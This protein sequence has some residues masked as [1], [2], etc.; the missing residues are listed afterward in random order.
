M[1]PPGFGVDPAFRAAAARA[2][3][4]RRRRLVRPVL[5]GL[6][7]LALATAGWR[8]TRDRPETPPAI[9]TG[10]DLAMVPEAEPGPET[11]AAPDPSLALRGLPRDPMVLRLSAGPSAPARTLPGPPGFEPGRAGPPAPDRLTLIEVG[12]GPGS[13]PRALDPPSSREDLALYQ[14]RR[15]RALA[16]ARRSSSAPGDLAL[17]LLPEAA[18]HPF[19]ADSLLR[20]G[21]GAD[22]TTALTGAGLGSEAARAATGALPPLA[23]PPRLAALRLRPGGTRSGTGPEPEAELLQLSLYGAGGYL[24]TLARLGA[25]RYA[26]AA[27]PWA[28]RDLASEGRTAPKAPPRL[29]DAVYGA[30]L[31]A[32]LGPDL[33][34]ELIVLLAQRMDLG[35]PAAPD[36]RLRVLYATRPGPGGAARLF[37]VGLDGRSGCYVLPMPAGGHACAGTGS[38]AGATAG[39]DDD[40]AV[41][42]LVARIVHVESGGRADAK[43][44]LSSA[45]GLGQFI[46]STWLRMMREHHP[47]LAARMDRA[48]LLALRTDP[49]LSVEMVYA[50]ARENAAYLAARGHGLTPGRLYL[51]HFLGAEGANRALSA[52]PA[53]GVAEIMGTAVVSA[54]PFLTGKTIGELLAWA[55]RKMTGTAAPA[56]VSPEIRRYRETVDA[57]LATG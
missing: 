28:D 12:L 29:L 5:L 57:I 4:R 55:D 51:A 23:D 32:G 16:Q 15:S 42:T 21:P 19:F 47:E 17:G 34:G 2:R 39:I 35:R 48:A 38:L 11:P 53:A 18:R 6:L 13:G 20:L 1:K 24:T 49:V 46:S 25:G 30:A 45:L 40:A 44:P 43:N 14:A 37:Y 54:N 52:D 36:Q 22:L 3:A 8:L 10:D 7:A 26:R 33:T 50:L 9:A 27:D 31:G 41:E 56:V